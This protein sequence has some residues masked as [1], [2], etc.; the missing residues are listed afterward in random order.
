M[1]SVLDM[2]LLLLI[3]LFCFVALVFSYYPDEFYFVAKTDQR[4]YLLIYFWNKLLDYFQK[5]EMFAATLWKKG[6]LRRLVP[7]RVNVC[8]I[9]D[10]GQT[11][12]PLGY[13]TALDF[14]WPG[15]K[16]YSKNPVIFKNGTDENTEKTFSL[17]SSL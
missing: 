12:R 5:R 15:S 4:N 16:E 6:E 3:L 9:G 14:I 13:K 1:F 10:H 17:A 8:L 7:R 2:I 11:L